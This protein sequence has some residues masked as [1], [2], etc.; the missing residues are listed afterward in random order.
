MERLTKRVTMSNSKIKFD[1]GEAYERMMGVWSR[2]VGE[3]FLDWLSLPSGKWWADIGCGNGAFSE[4]ILK[5]CDP[6]SVRGIDPSVAQID[7]AKSRPGAKKA[8]FEIGD[9]MALPFEDDEFDVVTMALALFFVPDPV[10]GVAEMKRVVRRDGV[11]AAYMWDMLG[12]GAPMEPIH[13]ALRLK[14]ISYPLPPSAEASRVDDMLELWRNAGFRSIEAKV[15]TVEREFKDFD[16]FWDT[17]TCSPAITSVLQ[18]LDVTALNEV[19]DAS[20]EF[21]AIKSGE[22]VVC[23]GTANCIKGVVH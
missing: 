19:K 4:Q 16:D 10:Q 3:K 8:I 6:I 5:V 18:G 11:V 21:L 20:R 7:F 22:L 12:G 14:R 1:D 9:A 17:T 2:Y 23:T 13:A 15:I